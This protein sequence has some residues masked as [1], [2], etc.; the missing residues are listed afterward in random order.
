[1]M[2]VSYLR[3]ALG[4]PASGL[5]GGTEQPGRGWRAGWEGV[6]RGGDL[7]YLKGG[8]E[9]VRHDTAGSSIT[10]EDRVN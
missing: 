5:G 2:Q 10:N 8:G 4:V 3:G 7:C 9:L 1:M 6:P